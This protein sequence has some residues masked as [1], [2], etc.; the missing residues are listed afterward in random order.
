M[1]P[2]SLALLRSCL[3]ASAL[4]LA[5]ALAEARQVNAVPG[6]VVGRMDVPNA[7]VVTPVDR[8]LQIA[9][10][11]EEIILF[12]EL[13]PSTDADAVLAEHFAYYAEQNIVITGDPTTTTNVL[14]SVPIV[15]M[16]LPA[17]WNGEPTNL[18][19]LLIIPKET[20]PNAPERTLHVTYWA[21]PKG[22]AA[23]GAAVDT[24]IESLVNSVAG[25]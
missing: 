19:Y 3:L 24:L 8:G 2:I 1:R 15:G 4:L 13:Y 25:P 10:R 22:H 20:R 17:T 6:A 16:R 23:Y 21:S 18:R 12:V 14:N 5:P 9:T 7:W 11:D